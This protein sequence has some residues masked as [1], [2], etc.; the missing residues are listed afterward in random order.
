M[1]LSRRLLLSASALIPVAACGIVST[2][3]TNGVTTLTVDVAQVSAWGQAFANAALLI[4]GLPGV[5]G[6]SVGTLIAGVSVTAKTD[7][8]AFT[9]F[10]GNNVSLSFNS[11]SVPAAISSLLA[12][13]QTLLVDAGGVTGLSSSVATTAQTYI[14]AISTLVALF[15]GALSS[16][17]AAAMAPKMTE[18]Q[19]LMA[20]GVK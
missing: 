14:D 7:L 6:T 12:D 20:L 16:G 19:A 11:T 17:V 8:A 1:P 4:S 13:G 3:T 18:A 15:Q 5:A 2:N 9:T 10:A